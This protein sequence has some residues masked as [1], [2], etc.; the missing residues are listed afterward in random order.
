MFAE[1]GRG[2]HREG[3]IH[4]VRPVEAAVGPVAVGGVEGMGLE[5][6]Q[7]AED[8][9]EG[10]GDQDVGGDRAEYLVGGDGAPVEHVAQQGHRDGADEGGGGTQRQR[11]YPGLAQTV[12][13][14]RVDREEGEKRQT[15]DE[16]PT[17]AQ[18]PDGQEQDHE[19]A[20]GQHRGADHRSREQRVEQDEEAEHGHQHA[21]AIAPHVGHAA[22][23]PA[24]DHVCI[25]KPIAPVRRRC[26]R[27]LRGIPAC[28]RGR[29]SAGCAASRRPLSLSRSARRCRRRRSRCG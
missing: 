11:P 26:R 3:K 9:G 10:E 8:T 15:P 2:Q 19:Q 25:L 4:Q 16:R 7:Q 20:G 21:A 14:Q 17:D 29:P 5:D 18:R 22:E 27:A 6:L 24:A 13:H 1:A 28:G 23:Q 12:G